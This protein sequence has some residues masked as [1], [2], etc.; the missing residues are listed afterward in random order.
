MDK[1]TLMA[2]RQEFF[3]S[4]LKC[5]SDGPS[6]IDK[7]LNQDKYYIKPDLENSFINSEYGDMIIQINGEFYE[8]KFNVFYSFWQPGDILKIGIAIND[9]ELQGAF[10]SDT[11]N[12]IYYIWGLKNEPVVDASHGCALYDWEFEVPNLYDDYK[13]QERFILGVRHMHFRVMRIMHD[14]CERAFFNNKTN[15]MII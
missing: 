14:E 11:Y 6:K 8:K 3:K 4:I 9:D 1:Q 5:L 13:N 10:I 12:E 15:V 2:K 7:I